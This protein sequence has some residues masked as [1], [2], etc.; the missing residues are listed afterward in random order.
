MIVTTGTSEY[1]PPD[2]NSIVSTA[3]ATTVTTASASATIPFDKKSTVTG[4][5]ASG[6]VS[7]SPDW[8]VT[9]IFNDKS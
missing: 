3:P 2:S 4:A 7:T 6:S 5:S 8:K 9:N 1:K